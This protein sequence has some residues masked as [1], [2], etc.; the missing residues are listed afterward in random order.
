MLH[1]IAIL[2][3]WLL[4]MGQHSRSKALFYYF[5]LEDQ[6]PEN[7]LLRLIDRH[8]NFEFIRAKPVS[9]NYPVVLLVG[10]RL[11]M[12]KSGRDAFRSGGPPGLAR[13]SE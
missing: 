7:H 12:G 9:V 6:V 1:A 13:A 11:E 4:M 2:G 3:G 10:R 8:V 5:R